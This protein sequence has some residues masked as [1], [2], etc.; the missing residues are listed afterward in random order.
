M[1][2]GDPHSPMSFVQ[3]NLRGNGIRGLFLE[4]EDI[5]FLRTLPI[6]IDFLTS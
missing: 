5:I 4:E 6:R 2:R 3:G 1:E